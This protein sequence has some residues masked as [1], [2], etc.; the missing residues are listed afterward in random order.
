ML[1]AALARSILVATMTTIVK[2]W[3]LGQLA[4]CAAMPVGLMP[5][6]TAFPALGAGL[7]EG[8]AMRCGRSRLRPLSESLMRADLAS[9][10]PVTAVGRR[11]LEFHSYRRSQPVGWLD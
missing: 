5:S 10:D 2:H 11:G 9:S 3:G 1:L 8:G 6:D 4:P 7:F